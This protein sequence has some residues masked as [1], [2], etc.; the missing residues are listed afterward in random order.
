MQYLNIKAGGFPTQVNHITAQVTC[1]VAQTPA[2]YHSRAKFPA[3]REGDLEFTTGTAIDELSARG[4][5][6][7]CIQMIGSYGEHRV[8]G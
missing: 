7:V 5:R 8:K 2:C 4:N 3:C 1:M 6:W